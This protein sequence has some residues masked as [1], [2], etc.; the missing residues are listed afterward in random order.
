[1]KFY[2]QRQAHWT[3]V[4]VFSILGRSLR[5]FLFVTGFESGFIDDITQL[6]D[7]DLFIVIFDPRFRFRVTD[8]RVYDAFG[9]F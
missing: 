9:F 3:S 5:R 8:L 6:G 2:T 4:P 7:G 1:M